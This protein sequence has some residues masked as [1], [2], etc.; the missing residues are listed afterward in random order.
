MSEYKEIRQELE[1]Y[2]HETLGIVVRH[3]DA[4]DSLAKQICKQ[5][6]NSVKKEMINWSQKNSP[7]EGAGPCMY[8]SGKMVDSWWFHKMKDDIK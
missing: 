7:P 2:N 6:E 1:R 8:R 4:L 3:S 5:K